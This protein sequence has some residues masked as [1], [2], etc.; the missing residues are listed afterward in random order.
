VSS[1]HRNDIE[2]VRTLFKE[3]V[4][5]Q[6]P[7]SIRGIV[8][9]IA[10]PILDAATNHLTSITDVRATGYVAITFH[11]EKPPPQP[12]P[13][14]STPEARTWQ[15]QWQSSKYA[16]SGGFTLVVVIADGKMNGTID[17]ASS[18]CTSSGTIAGVA[19]AGS[20]TFG[21][22]EAGNSVQFE[23]TISADGTTMQGAYTNGAECGED[24]GTW[25]AVRTA[26]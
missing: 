22:V 16:I 10:G 7:S 17:I 24:V 14:E 26:E 5:D 15:G 4:F 21:S 18:A 20:V 13:V 11:G 8:E 1:V 2:K 23:G 6:L 3:L 19:S 25:S 12:T 9:S